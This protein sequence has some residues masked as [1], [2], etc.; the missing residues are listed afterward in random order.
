MFPPGLDESPPQFDGTRLAVTVNVGVGA[1]DA[2]RDGDGDGLYREV[3]RALYRAKDLGRNRVQTVS[4]AAP[5]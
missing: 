2:A 1:F 3:D 4:S 5:A